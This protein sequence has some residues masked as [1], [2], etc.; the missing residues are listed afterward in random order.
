MHRVAAAAIV[1]LAAGS[2]AQDAGS[3]ASAVA[4]PPPPP[5]DETRRVLDYYF[6][7]KDRGPT[8][9]D[10]KAC[11]K[12][13]SAKDSPTRFE[14][15]EEV[16]GPVKV[17]ANVHA[18]LT[19]FVPKGASYDD[20]TVQFA[21]EGTVRSTVDVKL[22]MEMRVRTWR[23]QNLSKKGKWT[24]TVMRGATVLGTTTVTAE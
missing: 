9:I 17:N 6:N 10:L 15:L 12:V 4:A 8:L 21:H 19:F 1:L 13:D 20:V 2:F 14:C 3:A 11:L 18:W 24:I 7:G 23:S 16:K 5:A 22:D